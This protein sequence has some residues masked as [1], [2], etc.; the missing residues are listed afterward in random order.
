VRALD[1]SFQLA[2][3]FR[4]LSYDDREVGLLHLAI[5]ERAREPRRRLRRAREHQDTRYRAVDAVHESQ[6][7]VAGSMRRSTNVGL[8][9]VERGLVAGAIS[10]RQETGWF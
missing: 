7:H 8:T 9:R 6:E 10:L 2:R 1:E 5:M 3:V 4:E